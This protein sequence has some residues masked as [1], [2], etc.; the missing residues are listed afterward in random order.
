MPKSIEKNLRLG[1]IRALLQLLKGETV[2]SSRLSVALADE[3][4]A[5]GILTQISH[6]RFRTLVLANAEAL[7]VYLAQRYGAQDLEAWMALKSDEAPALRARQVAV[8]GDSKLRAS[9]TFRGFLVNSYVPIQ[10]MLHDKPFLM[11]PPL[12]TAF[13]IEDF[14]DFRIPEDVVVVGVENGE[15]FRYIRRQHYLFE[16]ITPLFVSRYPQS[17]DLRTWLLGIPNRYLHF[18]DFD[19]AGIH[20]FLSEFYAF[21]GSR[22]EFFQ[23]ADLEQRIKNGNRQLYD[24]QYAKY[25]SRPITDARLLPLVQLIHRCGRGYEQEGYIAED[26][27]WLG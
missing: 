7:G 6:G 22:A 4:L 12:G 21:L 15:N 2:P 23:P 20:I 8:A 19:L 25:H 9:R 16:G 24:K 5:E 13:F 27:E 26:E 17:S 18:G 11:S 14:E 1:D 10:A 3:L